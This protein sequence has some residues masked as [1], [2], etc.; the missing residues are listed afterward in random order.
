MPLLAT[1][2]LIALFAPVYGCMRGSDDA[3]ETQPAVPFRST[4]PQNTAHPTYSLAFFAV[5]SPTLMIK[6]WQP[7]CDFIYEQTDIELKIKIYKK[8]SDI[9]SL[10]KKSRIDLVFGGTFLYLILQKNSGFKPLV[11]RQAQQEN[12]H[13]SHLIVQTDSGI[14]DIAQLKGKRIAFTDISSSSGYLYPMILLAKAGITEPKSYFDEIIFTGN[15]YST[16][17]A[18][19]NGRVDAAGLSDSVMVD[20]PMQAKKVRSIAHSAPLP[21]GPISYGLTVAPAHAQAL[22]Q[23]FVTLGA[24]RRMKNF[25][26]NVGLEGFVKADDAEYDT[27]RNDM[28]YLEKTGISVDSFL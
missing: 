21:M 22:E 17:L 25:L 5:F 6:N 3:K 10:A 26:H 19:Y 2:L 9:I 12:L 24:L 11:K 16:L 20:Y 15:H 7:L 23:A 8:Y 27:I 28:K 4:P 14:D 1:A 13:S 18:V